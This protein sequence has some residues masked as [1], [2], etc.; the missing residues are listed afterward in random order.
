LNDDE[1]DEDVGVIDQKENIIGESRD[2][3]KNK[4]VVP[5]RPNAIGSTIK[6]VIAADNTGEATSPIKNISSL[7]KMIKTRKESAEIY[8]ANKRFD[9]H[10]VECLNTIHQ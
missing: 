7:Q 4:C 5:S 9:L 2:T 8:L 10:D 1:D 6:C 3:I